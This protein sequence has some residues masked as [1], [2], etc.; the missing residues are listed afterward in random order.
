MSARSGQLIPTK[1]SNIRL[2]KKLEDWGFVTIK[3]K[4]DFIVMEHRDGRGVTVMAPHIHRGN[5]TEELRHVYGTVC[6]GDA[7]K[8][9]SY[10]KPTAL[11]PVSTPAPAPAKDADAAP[12]PASVRRAMTRGLASAALECIM[13]NPHETH[14]IQSVAAALR[15]DAGPVSNA[16][17]YLCSQG[18]LVRILRG[19]YRLSPT[20][21]AESTVHHQHVGP[22]SV[23]TKW[24]PTAPVPPTFDAVM[25]QTPPPPP[26][27]AKLDPAY[28]EVPRQRPP[29]PAPQ[30]DDDDDLDALL[31]LVLPDH[32]IFQPRHIRAMRE[33]QTATAKLLKTLRGEA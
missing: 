1:I 24:E 25:P 10:K 13:G 28:M 6:N 29:A 4:G 18:H 27:T 11:T 32:Y 9:W 16:M 2:V 15:V 31:E 30:H 17:S 19:T 20:L 8:F 5:S 3:T 21:Q 33:W 26:P 22:V 23:T 12:A 7:A 14:T